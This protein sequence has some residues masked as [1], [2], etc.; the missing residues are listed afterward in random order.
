[1]L[2]LFLFQ[3]IRSNPRL[4]VIVENSGRSGIRTL[5]TLLEYTHFPGVPIKPLL[6]PS[7]IIAMTFIAG[8]K[9]IH[10]E[11]EIQILL[12]LLRE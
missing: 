4:L 12:Q 1:M 7:S 2:L 6:Q 5:G 3:I 11:M 9:I 10:P 8:C